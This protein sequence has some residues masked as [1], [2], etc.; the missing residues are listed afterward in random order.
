MDPSVDMNVAAPGSSSSQSST[1]ATKLCAINPIWS[2]K[3]IFPCV[4]LPIFLKLL[5]N[6]H[7]CAFCWNDDLK[8]AIELCWSVLMVQ[9]RQSLIQIKSITE[10]KSVRSLNLCRNKWCSK[11]QRCSNGIL[12][13]V[14]PWNTTEILTEIESAPLRGDSGTRTSVRIVP[15]VLHVAHF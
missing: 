8:L 9:C 11:D 4:S 7:F 5:A 1:K 13:R 3:P 6:V 15:I 14:G 10:N 2:P 12:N